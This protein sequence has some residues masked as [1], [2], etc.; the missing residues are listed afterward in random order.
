MAL[1]F[2]SFFLL[3]GVQAAATTNQ[4]YGIASAHPLATRA[5]ERI[6]RN[7]G[8]AFDA[9]IA[10]AS[11]LAVV[12]PSGSGLGGGG[13][14]LLHWAKDG[15]QVMLDAR[16]KAPLASTVDMYLDREGKPITGLSLNGPRAAGIPG[17]PA[18]LVHLAEHYGR[19]PLSQSLR[20][21]IEHARKGFTIG[22]H[23]RRLATMRLKVLRRY[24]ESKRIF[25]QDGAVP[26]PGFVLKQPDLAWTLQRIAGKGRDGFYDGPV[27]SKLVRSAR[28]HGGIWSRQDLR[29]Y[30][31][32]ER[33][34][35]VGHYRGTRIVSAPLPS[36]GGIVLVE[37]LNI[38]RRFP[39]KWLSR[40]ERLHIIVEAM[41]R[42]YRDRAQYLGDSDFIKIDIAGLLAPTYARQQ[43]RSINR[44]RAT[45]S[46]TLVQDKSLLRK[47]GSDTTHFSIIDTEG[48]RVSATLS[49]NY[50]FGSGFTARGTGVLL[51]NE[52]DDFSIKPGVPNVYG[53]VGSRANRIQPGKRPL[54]SMTPTFLEATNGSVVVLGTPGGSRIITMVLLA[55]LE[56]MAGRGSAKDWVT[57]PRFHHQFLPDSITFEPDALTLKDQ[58]KLQAKGHT[59]TQKEGGYGNMQI[60]FWNQ[61]QKKMSVASDPRGEGLAVTGR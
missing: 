28:R 21:A 58:R 35:I 46:A 11:T 5:G 22:P 3:Q 16:E 12:E 8:N 44:R 29:A 32:I 7:G 2:L 48:N 47:K 9:A 33:Q 10:V 25:L 53:L 49:I 55:S 30:R 14:F 61:A 50:P 60:V 41:R 37:M 19:L 23:Y 13:F 38:L 56:A 17:I 27:A 42:A 31:V 1:L 15:K 20:P 36:S 26:P 45:S 54:S 59:L 6:L 51:N 57:L 40:T 4:S 39:I 24:P 52:M 18:A 43:A 34:P